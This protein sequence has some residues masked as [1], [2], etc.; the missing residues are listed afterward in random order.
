MAVCF[1]TTIYL[2]NRMPKV[3]ISLDSSF[4]KLFNKAPN[5]SK[6]RVFGYFCFPWLRLTSSHKLDPESSSCV[7][8]GYS[9][10][11]AIFLC[12]DPTLKKIFVSCQVRGKR[13]PVRV[14]IYLLHIGN[15]H[16]LYTPHLPIHLMRLSC[17][18]PPPPPPP[19]FTLISPKLV[20]SPHHL[21]C[22]LTTLHLPE[23]HHPTHPP[24]KLLMPNLRIPHPFLRPHPTYCVHHLHLTHHLV[25]LHL[26]DLLP[27]T[28]PPEPLDYWGQL[29]YHPLL[30]I[31]PNL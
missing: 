6:L 17:S 11:Q 23:L 22:P 25:E 19:S 31:L 24:A 5:P 13:F 10:T 28:L 3:G 30:V 26:P 1:A 18:P 27:Q 29:P 8:L 15:R 7:F 20:C 16:R 4:E 9:L 14:S 12:F 21:T 2:I